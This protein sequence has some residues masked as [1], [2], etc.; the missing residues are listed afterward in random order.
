MVTG[1]FQI[2]F[3]VYF[4]T[5]QCL[6]KVFQLRLPLSQGGLPYVAVSLIW[7]SSFGQEVNSLDYVPFTIACGANILE[8]EGPRVST[9]GEK[10]QGLGE[11]S[12]LTKMQGTLAKVR[13]RMR[14]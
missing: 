11:D 13:L 4:S 10:S 14:S 9:G 12:T 8:L 7:V 6:V 5:G 1:T 2:T 3:A